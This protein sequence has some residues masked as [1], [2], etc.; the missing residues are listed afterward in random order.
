M[1]K[2]IAWSVQL[3]QNNRAVVFFMIACCVGYAL[4]KTSYRWVGDIFQT[5]VILGTLVS[6]Y[7]NRREATKEPL[8]WLMVLAVITPFFSWFNALFEYPSIVSSTPDLGA[9]FNFY[10]FLFVAYWIRHDKV[11]INS[12]MIA[13]CLGVLLT[14]YS[15]APDMVNEITRGLNGQ[16]VDFSY[17]NANHPA[18]LL[19]AAVIV[20]I[21]FWVKQQNSSAFF[22]ATRTSINIML[23]L[24]TTISLMMLVFTQSRQS[25]L[26]LVISLG[27]MAWAYVYR[28]YAFNPAITLLIMVVL[29]GLS[30]I[31]TAQIPIIN[32]RIMDE[33]DVVLALLSLDLDNIP[34]SSIGIRVHLW[35]ESFV[36]IKENPL[37]GLGQNGRALVISSSEV[38]PAFVKKDFTHLHNGYIDTLVNYGIVGLM[39]FMVS[40]Y[41]L[42]KRGMSQSQTMRC[43][44]L[45]VGFVSFFMVINLFESF[46]TFKSGEFIFNSVAAMILSMIY[47]D[48]KEVG[49]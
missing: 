42:L 33:K 41:S 20:A 47:N 2:N 27:L 46:L 15:H 25:W 9:I 17:V 49:L 23:I 3:S 14:M 40:I 36:W 26:A 44:S 35:S 22:G 10:F 32:D 7:I 21:S 6:I 19:G 12:F 16:R 4:F 30:A 1:K 31:I 13:F 48:K 11:Y 34:F 39:I 24:F 8:V 37:L 28:R 5:L 38:M 45:T 18:A 29:T 43:A